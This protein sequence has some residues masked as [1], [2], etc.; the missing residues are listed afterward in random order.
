MENTL[1]VSCFGYSLVLKMEVIHCSKMLVD[2]YRA[3]V[4]DVRTLNP[5]KK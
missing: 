2:I 5:T 4:N 3:M 1:L